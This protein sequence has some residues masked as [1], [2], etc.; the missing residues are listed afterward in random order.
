MPGK[1]PVK[2][3]L[4]DHRTDKSDEF[5][6]HKTTFRKLYDHE[7]TKYRTHGYFDVIFR[8]KNNEIT[9]GTISNIMIRTGEIYLTPPVSCGILAGTY[10]DY[11][12][13]KDDFPLKEGIL[14]QKDLESADEIF[15]INSVRKMIP[16]VFSK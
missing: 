7:L 5:L 9:E 8:N 10:R 16:A 15:V 3:A 1:L 4:S 14:H 2:I 12:L 13:K 11:L 6:Y